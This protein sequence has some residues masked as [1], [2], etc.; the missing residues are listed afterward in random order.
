MQIGF[1]RLSV[2]E[3]ERHIHQ[4]LCLY[5]G[6]SGHMR[7]SSPTHPPHNS[8][9]VIQNP[10][11]SSSVEI[12]VTLKVNGEVI[13]TMVLIDSGAAG[14][15]ID[16]DFSKTHNIP[17]VPC[18]SRLAV[19]ALDIR[20]LGSGQVQ[21]TTRDISLCTGAFHTETIRLFVFQS[22]QTPIIL[23]LPWLE[24]HNPCISWTEKQII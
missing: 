5:C 16:V 3:R 20:P 11:Q 2:E 21:F 15:F 18:E 10:S 22:P 4:N 7:A 1:T 17:L 9:T 8:S 14:N 23:G 6:L 13:N 12:P 19:A 24:N